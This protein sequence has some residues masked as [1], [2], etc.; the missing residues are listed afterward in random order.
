MWSETAKKTRDFVWKHRV[1]IGIGAV[2][3]AAIGTAVYLNLPEKDSGENDYDSED[4][5]LEEEAHSRLSQV[6]KTKIDPRLLL[7]LRKQYEIAAKNLLST[8]KV[9]IHE[10][11]DVSQVIKQIKEI[12]SAQQPKDEQKDLETQLWEEIKIASFTLLLVSTYMTCAVC[13]LLRVQLFILARSRNE[14][15]ESVAE[16]EIDEE[17]DEH[18]MFRL[19]VQDTYQHLYSNGLKNLTDLIRQRVQ[20]MM[21]EWSIK[22][23]MAVPYSELISLILRLRGTIEEDINR[24]VRTIIIRK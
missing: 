22:E 1:K 23:K 11:V 15:R 18:A 3:V 10:V 14:T 5:K 20:E 2:V 6:R 8:L 17:D 21:I 9:K 24:L 16:V 7:R 19:I 12:R 4:E 13:V